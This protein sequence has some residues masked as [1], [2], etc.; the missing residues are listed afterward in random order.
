MTA[1]FDF[2]AW[3]VSFPSDE[4]AL[5]AAFDQIAQ[6][7]TQLDRAKAQLLAI[8]QPAQQITRS[9][10]RCPLCHVDLNQQHKADCRYARLTRTQAG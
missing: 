3:R 2:L 7:S 1:G 4:H 9:N 8:A 5:R 10:G 6:L